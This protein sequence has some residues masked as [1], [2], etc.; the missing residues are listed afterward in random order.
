LSNKEL[1]FDT[2]VTFRTEGQESKKFVLFYCSITN[3]SII[4]CCDGYIKDMSIVIVDGVQSRYTNVGT[5]ELQST[6]VTI[7]NVVF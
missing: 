7:T 1:L 3:T 5:N 6:S 2:Y 4:F